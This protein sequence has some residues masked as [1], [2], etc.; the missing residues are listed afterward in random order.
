ML[1]DM[2]EYS[3]VGRKYKDNSYDGESFDCYSLIWYIYKCYGINIPKRMSNYSLRVIAKKMKQDEG[4]LWIPI[5]WKDR[6][7][8]DLLFFNTT[9][10]LKTHVGMVI[11]KTKFIHTTQ[12]TNVIITKNKKSIYLAQLYKVYRWYEL[13]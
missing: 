6:R 1:I 11:D 9:L 7:H 8:L 12:E 10:H 2:V 3:L 5:D 4:V 13:V